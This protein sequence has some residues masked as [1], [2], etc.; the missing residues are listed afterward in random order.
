MHP[1]TK[2]CRCYTLTLVA[3]EYIVYLGN[4]SFVGKSVYIFQL[5]GKLALFYSFSPYFKKI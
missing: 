1:N 3:T 4:V 2:L 5:P